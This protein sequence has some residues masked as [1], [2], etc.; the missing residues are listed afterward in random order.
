VVLPAGFNLSECN[1]VRERPVWRIR[2]AKATLIVYEIW[3]GPKGEPG[4]GCDRS[5]ARRSTAVPQ[6]KQ[7]FRK[8]PCYYSAD[9]TYS[10]ADQFLFL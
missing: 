9:S 5:S 7:H 6:T 3:Q 4:G 8:H 1:P 2:D 10:L